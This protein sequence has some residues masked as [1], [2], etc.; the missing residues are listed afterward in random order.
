[1]AGH[2]AGSID[3]VA[4]TGLGF[5]HFG[6]AIAARRKL[7]RIS[8]SMRTSLSKNLGKKN[9]K[10]KYVRLWFVSLVMAL[11]VTCLFGCAFTTVLAVTPYIPFKYVSFA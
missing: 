4:S 10:K 5:V 1:M 2:F 9:T 6:P 8:V 7:I 11:I 3:W